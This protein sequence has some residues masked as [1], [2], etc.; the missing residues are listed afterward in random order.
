MYIEP[1]S[2]I[3]LLKEVPLDNTYTHTIYFGSQSAQYNF[4]STAYPQIVYNKQSYQR[5]NKGTLRIQ[6]SIDQVYNCNYL[7]FLNPIF[8]GLQSK[9]FYAFI[10]KVDY[11]NNAVTEIT[12]ELD[13]MQTWFFDYDLH[14]SYIERSHERTDVVGDNIAPEPIDLGPIKCVKVND[15]GLFDLYAAVIC[16][17]EKQGG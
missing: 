1:N 13:V 11:I 9:W 6:A 10:T 3:R 7:M 2:T 14:P 12:Y 17:A 5:V 16:R 15:T 4:F 8:S